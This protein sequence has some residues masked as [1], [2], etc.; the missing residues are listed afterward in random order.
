M[1]ALFKFAA[2]A[3]FVL[4]GYGTD[5]FAWQ[6]SLKSVG[7]GVTSAELTA[8]SSPDADNV[9]DSDAAAVRPA[10]TSNTPNARNAGPRQTETP[11]V[12]PVVKLRSLASSSVNSDASVS[13]NPTPAPPPLPEGPQVDTDPANLV[14]ALKMQ[15]HAEVLRNTDLF[16]ALVTVDSG[17][18]T[19]NQVRIALIVDEGNDAFKTESIHPIIAE[20]TPVELCDIVIQSHPVVTL[21]KQIR[22]SIANRED[23]KKCQIDDIYFQGD[24]LVMVMRGVI[25]RNTQRA[26][27]TVAAA[28]VLSE[29]YSDRKKTKSE[30]SVPFPSAKELTLLDPPDGA[31]L[32]AGTDLE[33][34][35]VVLVQETPD[36][37]GS[38]VEVYRDPET[39]NDRFAVSIVADENQKTVP[40]QSVEKLIAEILPTGSVDPI[41]VVRHPAMSILG[42][43][44]AAAL[45]QPNYV[46][47]DGIFYPKLVDVTA[48]EVYGV[49]TK[50]SLRVEF[51]ALAGELIQQAYRGEERV[52]IPKLTLLQLDEPDLDSIKLGV[53]VTQAVDALV[54]ETVD[55]FGVILNQYRDATS[56]QVRYAFAVIADS[57]GDSNAERESNEQAAVSKIEK[58]L[59][60]SLP[61]ESHDSVQIIRQPVGRVL[62]EL[63]AAC[64]ERPLLKG[65]TIDGIHL[66]PNASSNTVTAQ[67]LGQ[68]T[69]FDQRSQLTTIA[70]EL[71]AAAYGEVSHPIPDATKMNLQGPNE[72]AILGT[73]AEL[74]RVTPPLT[75]CKINGAISSV[76][77]DSVL[78]DLSGVMAHRGQRNILV[79][80]VAEFLAESYGPGKVV[81]GTEDHVS[82]EWLSTEP[83]I[84]QLQL[85]IDISSELG[86]CVVRKADYV[87]DAGVEILE[88]VARIS[89][90]EQRAT[91]QALASEF[92][93]SRYGNWTPVRISDDSEV[94]PSS[95]VLGAKFFSE[96]VS[97][98]RRGNHKDAYK[99]FT[100]A[101]VESPGRLSYRYWRII[102]E[103]ATDR[104]GDAYRHVHPLVRRLRQGEKTYVGEYKGM[105]YSIEPVQGTVRS[106]LI[107]LEKRAS[108]NRRY[109]PIETAEE[110]R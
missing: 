71:L 19:A 20:K 16:G 38:A 64:S 21:L 58:L 53:E 4:S 67:L 85:E 26:R 100:N 56:E 1:K 47:I 76:D 89:R 18:L 91:L 32:K 108:N 25:T 31:S 28:E 35:L 102:T 2:V 95:R 24:P 103:I 46:R 51:R 73:L 81:V 34:Q 86:G 70:S 104:I 92:V 17:S 3:V 106:K 63:R 7:A 13:A 48:I 74:V 41:Q 52:P 33:T 36:L 42:P 96:G 11:P 101:N 77:G 65:V 62:S 5:C 50:P 84:S 10:E 94:I 57:S 49:I 69:R 110:L 40:T 82:V 54:G 44:Q 9:S 83:L 99:A 79:S 23:L 61:L 60:G 80:A 6:T 55:L 88:L 14:A 98:Y 59:A 90:T 43:L 37:F 107:E 8:Q 39:Q 68:L 30:F 93:R 66:D 15:L 45:T 12:A 78:V 97:L 29:I 109:A 22:G 75:G 72:Q 105:L 87:D 27:L